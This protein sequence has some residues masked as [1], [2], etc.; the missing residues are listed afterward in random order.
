M[1]LVTSTLNSKTIL[2]APA[3]VEPPLWRREVPVKMV[4]CCFHD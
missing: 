4:G 3:L 1:S 2:K